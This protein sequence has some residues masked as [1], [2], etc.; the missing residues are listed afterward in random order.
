MNNDRMTAVVDFQVNSETTTTDEWLHD[1]AARADDARDGEPDTPAYTSALN[2]ESKDSVLV[3]ERYAHGDE[4]LKKHSEREAHKHLYSRMGE[5]NMTKKRV[6][7]ARFD[8]VNNYAWWSRKDH[9]NLMNEPDVILTVLGMRFET[10]EQRDQF[11]DLSQVHAQYCWDEEPD[12]LIYSGGIAASDADREIDLRKGDLV[13]VMACTD[14]AAFEKHRDHP[15]H[16][17][18]GEKFA[19]AGINIESSF[20][21]TYR[22]TGHGYLWK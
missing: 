2:T 4:S 22:T 1:W 16:L 20:M 21:R 13:F 9:V 10:A 19:Q 12:T 18:L 15:N 6:M 14:L 11:I 7:S 17:A 5:Y 3:F 8:D